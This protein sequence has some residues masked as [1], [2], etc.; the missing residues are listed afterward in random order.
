MGNCDR[1]ACDSES[2]PPPTS[3]CTES[4]KRDDC[5]CFAVCS[6]TLATLVLLGAS[7]LAIE[8]ITWDGVRSDSTCDTPAAWI[9]NTVPMLIDDVFL[10]VQFRPIT[11]YS[12]G[13]TFSQ[14]ARSRE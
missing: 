10:V 1:S 12:Q 11:E 4:R 13:P 3:S 2:K 5:G 9:S 6:R 8:N 7:D 14:H